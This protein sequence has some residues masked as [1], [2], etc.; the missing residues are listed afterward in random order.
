MA[1][2]CCR[3]RWE[4][5]GNKPGFANLAL[6]LFDAAASVVPGAL[7]MVEGTGQ[8]VPSERTSEEAEH[9]CV[10]KPLVDFCCASADGMSYNWGDGLAAQPQVVSQF[11]GISDAS[12]FFEQVVTKPYANRVVVGEAAAV[13]IHSVMAATWSKGIPSAT[14]DTRRL[15]PLCRSPCVRACHLWRQG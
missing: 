11:P 6:G 3:L 1:S 15:H 7:F 8:I 2:P 4:A 10:C 12:I 13:H 9:V 5:Q 14:N